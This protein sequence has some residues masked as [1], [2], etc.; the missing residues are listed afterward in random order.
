MRS[1]LHGLRTALLAPVFVVVTG[2]LAATIAL[3][4]LLRR[5]APILDSII[6]WW[7]RFFLRLA[8][9]K[10]TVDGQEHIDRSGQYLFVANH[11]SNLDVAV[12]FLATRMPIRYLA[13][14]ELFKI[15]IFAQAMRGVG[16]VRTDRQAGKTAHGAINEGIADAKARGHSIIIFPEGTRADEGTLAP[17]KKGAFRIA[18]ANQLPVIPISIRGTWEMWKPGAKIVYPG[19]VHATVHPA[20]ST[21]GMELS[22][23]AELSDRCRAIIAAD[24]EA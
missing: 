5:D 1:V 15:P 6:M 10:L 18:I 8:G 12:M 23:I 17:F 9:G 7:S 4:A 24:L 3:I 13:K 20:I 22:D 2:V 19:S 14:K 11:E 16:I 21:E